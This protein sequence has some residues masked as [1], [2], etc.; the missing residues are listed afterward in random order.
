MTNTTNAPIPN[1]YD[2]HDRIYNF[3]LRVI[4]LTKVIPKTQ[5]NMI[6]VNQIL[7]SVTS[8]GANDQE[9]DGALTRKDFVHCYI[10]V[11]KEAKETNFADF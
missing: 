10:I 11:R 1:K 8:V 2:I 7:R 5:T 3:I 9:A 4:N 6:L